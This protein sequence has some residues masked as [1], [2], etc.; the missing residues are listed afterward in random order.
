MRAFYGRAERGAAASEAAGCS[1]ATGCGP[2]HRARLYPARRA[3]LDGADAQAA[4][5]AR[6]FV[7]ARRRAVAGV[8]LSSGTR[9]GSPRAAGAPFLVRYPAL[10]LVDAM[11]DP[12]I[13]ALLRL[14]YATLDA[15]PGVRQQGEAGLAAAACQPGYG[16]ALA[17]VAV[18]QDLP[19][20]IKQLAAVV[21][22]QYVKVSHRRGPFRGFARSVAA[23][24]TSAPRT[25]WLPASCY[26][27]S[28]GAGEDSREASPARSAGAL[29]GQPLTVGEPCG[30]PAAPSGALAGGRG[31]IH[32]AHLRRRRKS[33]HP[34]AASARPSRPA[35]QD[36]HRVRH[37]DCG[38]S[39][40]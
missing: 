32:A 4:Y 31:A 21:L 11:A 34:R 16:L 28:C 39:A 24:P 17:H 20:G 1:P 23:A 29:R 37:G 10:L 36:S 22:K 8:Q 13:D 15:T 40:P 26:A 6:Q 9:V 25:H 18:A 12:G 5:G 19:Y 2:A 7:R 33:R 30:F 35:R 27:K 14:L 3:P 38:D